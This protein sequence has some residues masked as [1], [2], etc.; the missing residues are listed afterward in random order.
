MGC[1]A[2]FWAAPA[3]SNMKVHVRTNVYIDGFN[4]YYGAVKGTPFRWLDIS[5]FCAILLPRDTIHR[6][7]YYTALVRPRPHD[8]DQGVRQATFL[9][10]LKTIPNLTI[11]KGHFLSHEVM[12]PSA[13]NP[14]RMVKV[15]KTEEKG[16][17]VNLASHLL[18]DAFV[19]DFD[20]AVVVSNDSDLLEPI[21]IVQSE[22]RKPVGV[23]NPQKHP[24]MVLK[25]EA[26]FFK[27]IR[28]SALARCQFPPE[29]KD[30]GG[31]FKKPA[32]W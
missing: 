5:K 23:L 7:R 17:D 32:D 22:F 11:H 14:A 21:R 10:A 15:I 30:A 13:A 16:S 31:T 12:M 25:K 24:S 1:G 29:L 8:P 2:A 9:R 27:S 6:I 28:K 20:I 26:K 18:R 3:V 4:L 19:D